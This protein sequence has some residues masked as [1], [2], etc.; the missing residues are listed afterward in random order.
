MNDLKT[1]EASLDRSKEVNKTYVISTLKNKCEERSSTFSSGTRL[2][3]QKRKTTSKSS[4]QTAAQE[5]VENRRDGSRMTLKRRTRTGSVDKSIQKRAWPSSV[6]L[7]QPNNRT[8]GSSA[9]LR[10]ASLRDTLAKR[11]TK[12]T[13]EPMD[14]TGKATEKAALSADTV[15]T[16]DGSHDQVKATSTPTGKTQFQKLSL[17]KEVFERLAT[18]DI[19]NCVSV[20]RPSVE[21]LKQSSTEPDKIM[22][23]N[24]CS[25]KPLISNQIRNLA[26]TP[27]PAQVRKATPQ[28]SSTPNGAVNFTRARPAAAC[29]TLLFTTAS[30]APELKMEN[31]AVTVAVRVRPFNPR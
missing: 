11:P 27:R 18:R 22:P 9:L 13:L 1:E 15:C 8:P 7:S 25:K 4:E 28:T 17:K 29:E 14:T 10:S 12:D 16:T 6:V 24:P 2:T 3:L 21:R 19:S 30:A 31:S 23:P 26:A 5:N 20:K